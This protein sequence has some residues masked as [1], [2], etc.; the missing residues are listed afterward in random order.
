MWCLTF[1]S[2]LAEDTG[3]TGVVV[4]VLTVKCNKCYNEANTGSSENMNGKV[5]DS[6]W[7]KSGRAIAG[8]IWV[9]EK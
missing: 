9:S 8:P 5:L 7:F 1:R 3:I 4:A 6:A 2:C